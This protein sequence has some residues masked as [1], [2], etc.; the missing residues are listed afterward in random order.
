MNV[1]AT[2]I[3][4]AGGRS[5]RMGRPKALL[6]FDGEPLIVHIVRTLQPLFDEI[7]VVAAPGQ[8]LP[9]MPVRLVRDDVA[10]QGP[11]GGIYYGLT[12]SS[13]E[14]CFITSC[15]SAF[16]NVNLIAHLLALSA[17]YDVVV[18]Q[19]EG[20]LQPLHAAYRRTVLPILGVQLERGDLRPVNLFDKVRTRRVD[21]DEIRRFDPDGSSFFNMNTPDDYAEAQRLWRS[22]A[23][24]VIR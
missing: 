24:T 17:G 16:L 5:S 3:V 12:A 2:A 6:P 10:F 21:E 8:A 11:V 18:A 9:P 13:G 23:E 20:R 15:D 19:W 14:T 4:L 7:V 1:S 22:R